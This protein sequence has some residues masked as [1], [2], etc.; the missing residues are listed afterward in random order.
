VPT[1]KDFT[2]LTAT[3]NSDTSYS[4]TTDYTY[5]IKNELTNESSTRNG[6]YTNAFAYDSAENPTT[7][8]GV[9][10]KTYNSDNQNSSGSYVFD[11]DGNP[12]TYSGSSMVFDVE[13]RLTSVGSTLTAGY[14]ANNMRAWK[15]DGA[16][17]TYYLYADNSTTPVC[18]LNASGAVVATNTYT[19]NGLVSRNTS[20]GS[21]FYEFDPQGT[22][23]QRL[24]SAG[25]NTVTSTADS[26]GVVANS[27]SVS[28]PF[29]YIGQAGYYT[30]LSTGLILTT[31]RYY[32]PGAGRFL[33]RD[34]SGYPGGVD[35]YAYVQN[36]AENGIDPLGYGAIG[37][38]V[39]GHRPKPCPCSPASPKDAEHLGW[40]ITGVLGIAF[41]VIGFYGGLALNPLYGCFAGA[42]A[43][44][45]GQW[46]AES[47]LTCGALDWDNVLDILESAVWGC[48]MGG[49][50]SELSSVS[51]YLQGVMAPYMPS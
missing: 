5:D 15:T 45:L 6:G 12:T 36:N 29:G 27:G 38:P 48:G 44:A 19:I 41:T 39:W 11:G 30:D 21:T 23:A 47:A 2:A 16:G 1:V 42:A 32:D 10:G 20:A 40:I 33:N 3:V 37:A 50:I 8:R 14:D 24:N 46:A 28:D 35:L 43:N 22:V 13:N 17:T 26:F 49:I 9:S 4:G 25:T 34:P 31:H 51:G 18:E 7:F